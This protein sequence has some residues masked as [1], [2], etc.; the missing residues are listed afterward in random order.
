M[1]QRLDC[2]KGRGRMCGQEGFV[3]VWE[4]AGE[5]LPWLL[6]PSETRVKH[7]LAFVSGLRGGG[8][9]RLLRGI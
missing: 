3:Y 4:S 8:L 2:V 1:F 7:G 9:I 6:L 5:A